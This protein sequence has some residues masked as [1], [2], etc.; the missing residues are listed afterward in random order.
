MV[1]DE[2]TEWD[3]F[4]GDGPQICQ[5]WLHHPLADKN[6][7]A[8][9]WGDKVISC[10]C[11]GGI[12]VTFLCFGLFKC[13]IW[14]ALSQNT[15]RGLARRQLTPPGC[16]DGF[17]LMTQRPSKPH[18]TDLCHISLLTFHSEVP[19][20]AGD[21]F[22]NQPEQALLFSRILNYTASNCLQGPCVWCLGVKVIHPCC[23]CVQLGA[24]HSYWAQSVEDRQ[25]FLACSPGNII[26]SKF[27]LA[28]E[29]KA[30]K[31]DL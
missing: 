26:C 10:L 20:R 13:D 16:C 23:C 1:S 18:R 7:S 29:I 31:I 17:G 28:K 25:Q 8:I 5:P 3:H 21:T 4:K 14:P 19:L 30:R 9:V 15:Q 11:L 22:S 24:K 2:L 27:L 12:L 6:S